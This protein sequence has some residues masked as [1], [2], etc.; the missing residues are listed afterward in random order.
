M[1]TTLMK[2]TYF[3]ML[4]SVDD[5]YENI[6]MKILKSQVLMVKMPLILIVHFFKGLVLNIVFF[7]L[8][9]KSKPSI[10]D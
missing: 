10:V 6:F 3:S 4:Q 1:V 8:V 5:A 9:S 7:L 2:E